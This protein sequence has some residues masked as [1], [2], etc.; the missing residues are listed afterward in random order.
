M[1]TELNNFYAYFP[2]GFY[3]QKTPIN[4]V[5]DPFKAKIIEEIDS[6]IRETNFDIEKY[7]RIATIALRNA[8]KI[9]EFFNENK[10]ALHYAKRADKFGKIRTVSSPF[11]FSRVSQKRTE[12]PPGLGEHTHEILRE[13]GY[14][15]HE[16]QVLKK[17]GIC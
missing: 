12:L 17:E 6:L 14:E 8:Q 16:I 5:E 9:S 1:E 10:K 7:E 3:R 2:M 15:D 13:L 11:K 4:Y